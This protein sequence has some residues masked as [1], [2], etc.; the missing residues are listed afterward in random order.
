[1]EENIFR[2]VLKDEKYDM[3]KENY[4]ELT[5]ICNNITEIIKGEDNPGMVIMMQ[6]FI[7]K[8]I[9]TKAFV[10]ENIKSYIDVCYKYDN[11]QVVLNVR[12]YIVDLI[13]LSNELRNAISLNDKSL[14][15]KYNKLL[16]DK[17]N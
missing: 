5:Q 11:Q 6:T 12:S 10:F 16:S 1:M 15:I 17:L 7:P 14:I 8:R 9:E 13:I 3:F 4:N 2:N